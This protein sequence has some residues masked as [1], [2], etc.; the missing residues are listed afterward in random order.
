[1]LAFTTSTS[2]FR[3]GLQ[4]SL[5][6][7]IVRRA[8]GAFAAAALIIAPVIASAAAESA[9]GGVRALHTLTPA[10]ITSLPDSTQLMFGGV[11]TTLGAMRA[12]HVKRLQRF[13]QAA[14]L[15]TKVAADIRSRPPSSA[16]PSLA[17]SAAGGQAPVASGGLRTLGLAPVST[18]TPNAQHPYVLVGPIANLS[19]G[20]TPV[21]QDARD[22]C[23]AAAATACLYF[24]ANTY[25]QRFQLTPAAYVVEIDPLIS[26]GECTAEGGQM[27]AVGEPIVG[28]TDSGCGFFY[29]SHF[30]GN[31]NPGNAAYGL[32]Q[33]VND[34][35]GFQA[36]LDTKGAIVLQLPIAGSFTTGAT[37]ACYI[38][39]YVT[40]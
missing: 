27:T 36:T 21:P 11:T 37:S 29:L 33:F 19:G 26:S 16:G 17:P 12:T 22:V 3:E 40:K 6:A 2:T 4:M 38:E 10:Q 13:A 32:P 24:P 14:A 35:G 34:C 7:Q 28:Y 30:D 31:F 20:S 1:M 5:L 25:L 8:A 23:A 9:V 39:A 15:G 18:A